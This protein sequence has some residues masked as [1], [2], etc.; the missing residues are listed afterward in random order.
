MTTLQKARKALELFA[1]G[2][3]I[4]PAGLARAIRNA[5]HDPNTAQGVTYRRSAFVLDKV[6]QDKL[7]IELA[8]K[9]AERAAQN[10]AKTQKGGVE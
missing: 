6:A 10:G 3:A 9:Q 5:Q 8:R 2:K 1:K 4:S 7:A